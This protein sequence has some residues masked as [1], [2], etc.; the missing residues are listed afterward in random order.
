MR[1]ARSNHLNQGLGESLLHPFRANKFL[2]TAT[3]TKHYVASYKKLFLWRMWFVTAQE[4]PCLTVPD[5]WCFFIIENVVR[6][7]VPINNTNIRN[8]KVFMYYMYV[9]VCVT[10]RLRNAESIIFV[11]MISF[12]LLKK[13][14][15]SYYHHEHHLVGDTAGRNQSI[16]IMIMTQCHPR[17]FFGMYKERLRLSYF[18]F[19]ISINSWILAGLRDS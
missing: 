3:E 6:L 12:S 10:P 2:P 17:D 4:Q 13:K 18:Y 15:N 14:Q 16:F 8:A 5:A 9:C 19:R 1:T 11:I 7:L